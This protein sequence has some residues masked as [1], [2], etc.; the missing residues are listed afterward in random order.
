MN[1]KLNNLLNIVNSDML[2]DM[3]REI[4]NFDSSL[5]Y[6]DF[7]DMEFLENYLSVIPV[8]DITNKIYYGDF[9]PNDSYF[10]FNAYGNLITYSEYEVEQELESYKEEIIKRFIELY[11]EEHIDSYYQEVLDILDEDIEEE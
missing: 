4:N 7:I 8:L 10:M 5:D 2:M 3:T 11:E 9:N 1:K 6:L